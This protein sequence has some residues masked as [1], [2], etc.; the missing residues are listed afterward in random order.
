MI[1]ILALNKAKSIWGENSFEFK[2]VL[3]KFSNGFLLF[4]Q[5]PF[6]KRPE[7]WEAIPEAAASIPGIWGHMLTFLGGP[8]SCIGYRF[9]LI[10]YMFPLSDAFQG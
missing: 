8:R 3:S 6:I 9:A 4:I 1:P 5:S 2:C 10:E 7:R